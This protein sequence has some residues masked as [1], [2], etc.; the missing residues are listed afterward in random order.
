MLVNF[1][2]KFVAGEMREHD[3]SIKL[4]SSY[5]QEIVL[6]KHLYLRF[7]KAGMFYLQNLTDSYGIRIVG[8][9]Y[10]CDLYSIPPEGIP[11]KGECL[12]CELFLRI[13]YSGYCASNIVA[14]MP[15]LLAGAL[16][17]EMEG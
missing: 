12:G 1:S 2:E 6:I 11:F 13:R 16:S 4:P 15:I 8:N 17:V 5:I 7:D 10:F 14:G 9:N 3:I